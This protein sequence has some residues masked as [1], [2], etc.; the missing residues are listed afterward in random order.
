MLKH[1]CFSVSQNGFIPAVKNWMSLYNF[2]V[3]AWKQLVN[4]AFIGVHNYDDDPQNECN[5][6]TDRKYFFRNFI[7]FNDTSM[8]REIIES[9]F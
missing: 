4:D 9:N 8:V 3:K 7:K 2:R 1:K 6:G 5:T